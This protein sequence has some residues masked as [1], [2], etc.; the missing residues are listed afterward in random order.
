M[1]L[2]LG[3]ITMIHIR[4]YQKK[5]RKT[6]IKI[7]DI[8]IKDK[9]T[10]LLGK[11]GSGKSTLLKS[12]A[13]LLKFDGI[14]DNKDTTSYMSEYIELPKGILL[15][16]LL[17]GI[18]SIEEYNEVFLQDLL[19]K[20]KLNDYLLEYVSE[21]SKGMKCKVNLL[22]CLTI[23]RDYYLLDEPL[24]GLDEESIKVLINVIKQSKKSFVITSHIKGIFE[25]IVE[26]VV[27]LC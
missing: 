19:V 2:I 6:T 25:D 13:G 26:G 9:V 3:T 11:N 8:L 22:L 7:S 4:N 21:F 20:L 16:D 15:I 18:L 10:L 24:S 14:I 1:N 27:Y 5:Y 12:I 17:Q 23:N